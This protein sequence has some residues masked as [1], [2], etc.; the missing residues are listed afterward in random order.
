[1]TTYKVAELTGV[2]L[3]AAVAMADGFTEFHWSDIQQSFIYQ[4]TPQSYSRLPEVDWTLA[5]A[6]I[7]RERISIEAVYRLR[8]GRFHEWNAKSLRWELAGSGPTPLIAAMRAFV[9]SKFGET[10][11]LP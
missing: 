9:A 5:G 11:D 10:I 7:E 8:G 2:H 4:S 1:M 6:I 3:D